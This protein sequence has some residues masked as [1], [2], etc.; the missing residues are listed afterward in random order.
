MKNEIIYPKYNLL[1]L[2]FLLILVLISAYL[3]QTLNT[4]QSEL[5]RVQENRYTS[6]LLASQ[7][8]RSSDELTRLV[9]AYAITGNPMYE[10]QFLDVQAIRNGKSPRPIHY[11][12]VY[13]D[14]LAINDGVSPYAR[15]EPISLESLVKN[16]GFSKDE[17][18]L[19]ELSRQN[20]DH[21]ISLEKKSINL[22]KNHYKD[23]N[24]K[25]T[26]SDES[27][28]QM[29]IDILY[30]DEYFNAKIAIM[31]PINQFYEK[32]DNRTKNQV[33]AMAQ[34]LSLN[35]NFQV[36]V[37]VLIVIT[38]LVLILRA[39]RY[40]KNMV[41][42][43]NKSVSERTEELRI[44][45]QDLQSSLDEIKTIQGI[46]PICSYCHSI[47]DDEGS[48]DQLESY[49]SKNSDAAFSHG[50]CPKCLPKV[51]TEQGLDNA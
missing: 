38:I 39:S 51:R 44:T 11:D 24:T 23:G 30:G 19:L 34:Q 27:N 37:F 43:L 36:L 4:N 10:K 14:F 42:E 13:W 49:I 17:L 26:V 7:L 35:L 40:H 50:I 28:K 33:D 20:S 29:A 46:I 48:W 6:Y 3:F 21:L 41:K 25:A 32:L 45:N 18:Q 22:I 1:I 5:V 9:R 15:G 16:A 47:R 12:R 31:N 2:A 8:R